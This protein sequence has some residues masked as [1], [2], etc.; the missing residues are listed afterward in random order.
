[1]KKILYTEEELAFCLENKNYKTFW[2]YYLIY[3]ADIK[4]FFKMA[5][6][7]LFRVSYL[8]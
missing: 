3:K 1:M 7:S 5:K 2:S 4:I 8:S 6:A